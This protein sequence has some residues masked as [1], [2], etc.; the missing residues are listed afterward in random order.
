MASAT[1][2]LDADQRLACPPRYPADDRR[3]PGTVEDRSAMLLASNPREIID[4]LSGLRDGS[5][6]SDQ[7]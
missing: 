2:L 3:P 5:R 1:V 7:R 4:G 6:G